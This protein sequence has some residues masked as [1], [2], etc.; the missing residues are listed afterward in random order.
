[1]TDAARDLLLQWEIQ[2]IFPRELAN[3]PDAAAGRALLDSIGFN[4]ES[5][6]NKMALF[7]SEEMRDAMRNTPPA[8]QEALIKSGFGWNTQ[9]SKVGSP[10]GPTRPDLVHP[11]YN[12]FAIEALNDLAVEAERADWDQQAK[13]R[14]VFDLHRF[15]TRMNFDGVPPV[16]GTSQ[17]IFRDAWD[18]FRN[19]RDYKNLSAID[20]AQIDA[21]RSEYNATPIDDG[22]KGNR[23]LRLEV[24]EKLHAETE[25]VLT[26][27]QRAHAFDKHLS[28]AGAAVWRAANLSF[29]CVSRRNPEGRFKN[30]ENVQNDRRLIV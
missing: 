10:G 8:I 14:A 15:M 12:A 9:N 11:N 21:F 20:R 30:P 5:R 1:M 26:E 17:D 4:L 13:E 29:R 7:S 27:K 16:Q 28:K 3:N 6:G 18:A 19:G 24:A 22:V 23:Q 25:G 2:H